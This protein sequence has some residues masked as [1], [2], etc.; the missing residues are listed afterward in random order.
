M[1]PVK[2]TGPTSSGL[3]ELMFPGGFP[4]RPP[5]FHG[6]ARCCAIGEAFLPVKLR[7]NEDRNAIDETASGLLDLFD[8]PLSGHLRTNRQVGTTRG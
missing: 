7:G 8:I 1:G 5:K 2:G 4:L 6:L 3:L